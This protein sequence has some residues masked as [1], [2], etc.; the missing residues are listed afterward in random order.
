MT[1][2][3]SSSSSIDFRDI[4]SRIGDKWAL[5]VV[6]AL[7][8]GS[9]RFSEVK[10]GIPGISQRMLTLTLRSLERDGLV[11]RTVM[12]SIPQR[13]DY[14]LTE[15]GRTVLDPAR[16]LVE[17]VDNNRESIKTANHRHDKRPEAIPAEELMPPDYA[18]STSPAEKREH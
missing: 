17:W 1:L 11:K 10:R 3:A 18:A 12:T 2:S 9:R 15:L 7:E 16:L 5:L 13:V 4:L 8:E 14:E 6:R